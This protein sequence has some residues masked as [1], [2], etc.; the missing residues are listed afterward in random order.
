MK[1]IKVIFL[2]LFSF[3]SLASDFK[4]V[5]SYLL[6]YSVFKVDVYQI[7]YLKSHDA[8]KLVLEYKRDVERKHS[9]EGWKVGLAHKL[10]DS[11]YKQKAEWLFEHT[12]DVKKGDTVSMIKTSD[13]LEIYVNQKLMGKTSDLMIRELSF[14]PWLGEKPVDVNLKAALLRNSKKLE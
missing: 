12:Y 1:H 14:E 13:T 8:E 6:E 4:V 3:Q 7:T 2:L 5:G 10:N 9:L 11:N